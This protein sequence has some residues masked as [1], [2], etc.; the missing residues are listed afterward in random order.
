MNETLPLRAK[1][2][3]ALLCVA[4]SVIAAYA[5]T[6]TTTNS[7]EA[8]AAAY[9][10]DNCRY[11]V[12]VSRTNAA[13]SEALE[14]LGTSAYI[15]Y[16]YTENPFVLEHTAMLRVTQDQY[17]LEGS[18]QPANDSY[19]F[20]PNNQKH[21]KF[22][23]AQVQSFVR[24]EP[25][26]LW[27]VGNEPERDDLQDEIHP[28]VYAQAYHDAYIAIKEADPTAKVAIAS[29]IEVT[30]LRLQY[31]QL[32]LDYYEDLYGE[33]MPIDV[34]NTHVYPISEAEYH[35]YERDGLFTPGAAALPIGVPLDPNQTEATTGRPLMPMFTAIK[36]NGSGGFNTLEGI[37]EEPEHIY[38]HYC[39]ADAD[40]LR[41]FKEQ[42]HDMRNFMKVNGYQDTPLV[43][44]EFG[45]LAPYEI[46]RWE[47]NG[48]QKVDYYLKDEFNNPFPPERVATF[49][50]GALE[51]LNT[52]TDP[53][54]GYAEDGNRLVQRWYWFAAWH[55]GLSSS[56]NL[57]S[58]SGVDPSTNR[59]GENGRGVINGITLQGNTF[60]NYA[61]KGLDTSINLSAFKGDTP[62]TVGFNKVPLVAYV[63]NTGGTR[64]TGNLKVTFYKDEALTQP[65]KT[66]T[67][68]N[69]DVHGCGMTVTQL[70][71]SWV[72]DDAVPGEYKYWYKIDPANA[73]DEN[74]LSTATD[75][76]L[77]NEDNVGYGIGEFQLLD[78]KIY[79]PATHR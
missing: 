76:Y 66:E 28:K 57:V 75:S 45:I 23:I 7:V 72:P 41:I 36:Y 3:M 71:T 6:M 46:D 74:D 13:E 21:K 9:P 69:P 14:S 40:N 62:A 53:D 67:F 50:E 24:A 64:Y 48:E 20:Y 18:Q 77:E 65:I 27:L 51:Y 35:T 70:E 12:N 55:E 68:R 33:Q 73:I 30:P 44:T 39:E 4:A 49:M 22:S 37:C 32:T 79:L 56:S 47:E 11:G 17:A 59:V 31:L 52:A 16:G 34:W 10:A 2:M 43:I 61:A 42:I 15:N 19:R 78:E 29:I 54:L 26:K 5:V 25:G 60:K 1:L 8:S 38:A 58:Y 63:S